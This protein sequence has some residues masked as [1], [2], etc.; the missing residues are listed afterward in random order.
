MA[1]PADHVAYA[2]RLRADDRPDDAAAHYERALSLDPEHAEAHAAYATLL[3]DDDPAAAEHHYRE[4]LARSPDDPETLSDYG[5]LLYEEGRLCEAHDQLER[6][7]DLWLARDRRED[8]L[9]DVELLVRIDHRL[10]RPT[11]A[12]ARWRYALTLLAETNVDPSFGRGLRAL[13]TVLAA[14]DVHDR[15]AD[16]VDLGV[17]HLGRGEFQQAIHLFAPAWDEHDRLRAASDARGDARCAGAALAGFHRVAGNT[18]EEATLV[19]ELRAYRNDLAPG[20]RAVYDR[21]VGADGRGPDE[22][23]RLA[24]D[25]GDDETEGADVGPVDSARLFAFADLCELIDGT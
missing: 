14:R 3:D 10:D 17:E 18:R 6:A 20:P 13:G 4:A 25:L 11:A 15:V 7:V 22:L 9:L 8:A 23:R 16:A 24:T 5:V 19:A 2:G 12:V 21:L 1:D